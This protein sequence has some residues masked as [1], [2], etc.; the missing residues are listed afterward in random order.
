MVLTFNL[1]NI[2]RMFNLLIFIC[3]HIFIF[4]DPDK[5]MYFN[6]EAQVEYIEPYKPGK[7]RRTAIVGQGGQNKK[8]VQ[9]S[10][11]Q[12]QVYSNLQCKTGKIHTAK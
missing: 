7:F 10:T 12:C 3:F 5:S 9:C 8:C 11:V 6:L 2:L 1:E 4:L